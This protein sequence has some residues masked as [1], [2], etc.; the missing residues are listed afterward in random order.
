M[1]DVLHAL[2]VTHVCLGNHEDDVPA[3]ALRMR[4]QEHQYEWVNTNLRSLDA[5]LG[6]STAEYDIVHL[7]CGRSVALLGLMSNAQGLYRP[8]AF[9]GTAGE[10]SEGPE[11]P[12]VAVTRVLEASP[13][14]RKADLVVPLTH[15]DMKDDVQLA[16]EFESTAGAYKKRV[17]KNLHFPVIIGGHDHE[18][19]DEVHH[20]CRILKAG[21]DAHHAAV[22][23]FVWR[24]NGAGD[25]QTAPEMTVQ[26]INAKDYEANQ[27]VQDLMDDRRRVLEELETS[28]LIC[29]MDMIKDM[30]RAGVLGPDGNDV[31]STKLNRFQTT[32]ASTAICGVIRRGL[33]AD[34]CAI[35]AGGL[36]GNKE[37]NPEGWLSYADLKIEMPFPDSMVVVPLPGGV[38]EEAVVFSRRKSKLTPPE[39]ESG[40]LHLCEMAEY[41]DTNGCTIDRSEHAGW[42]GRIVEIGGQP[43]NPDRIYNVALPVA[44]V[45]GVDNNAPILEWSRKSGLEFSEDTGKPIKVIFVETCALSFW[46]NLGSFSDID[47]DGDGVITTKKIGNIIAKNLG[48]DLNIPADARHLKF[49]VNDI[50]SVADIDGCGAIGVEDFLATKLTIDE[51]TRSG[52]RRCVRNELGPHADASVF[53]KTVSGVDSSMRRRRSRRSSLKTSLSS[54]ALLI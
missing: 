37:Y 33:G 14:V 20:G 12:C 47:T 8:G 1:A 41:K 7:G 19:M 24:H 44:L 23:E 31:F 15:Q 3:K 29:I 39:E 11:S 27:G 9:E 5:A 43:F 50:M 32:L 10:G 4:I 16:E 51:S 30:R 38:L 36:R 35:N 53:A 45:K 40:F 48:L 6:V 17:A 28:Q 52:I 25:R 34:C 18:V 46:R 22:V 49:L 21:S 54:S 13:A 26:W 2:G 42:D